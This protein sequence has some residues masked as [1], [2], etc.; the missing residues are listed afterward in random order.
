LN[1]VVKGHKW[2]APFSFCDGFH[3]FGFLWTPEVMKWYVD[4]VQRWS[5][6][7]ENH[8]TALTVN[9]DS[10]TFPKWS[11]MPT[12]EELPATF[13]IDYLRCW[14]LPDMKEETR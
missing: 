9:F 8:K 2:T 4:G 3:R 7:N 14:Q 10:E 11:G 6:P 5:V 1:N 12:L 13:Y